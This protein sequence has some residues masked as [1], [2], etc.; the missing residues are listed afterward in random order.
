[1]TANN[2]ADEVPG[3]QDVSAPLADDYESLQQY[4]NA[5]LAIAGQLRTFFD[6][7]QHRGNQ[8]RIQQCEQLT[9]KLAEDRFTIAVLGQFKRGKSSLLNAII[10]RDLLPTGI[11]PLTSVI[12]VVRYGASERLVIYRKTMRFPDCD[13]IDTLSFANWRNISEVR[14]LRSLSGQSMTVY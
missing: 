2:N 1:V 13:S 4:T 14:R 12:T 6:L 5:K 8:T 11:L 9:A 3:N 10:G 7:L